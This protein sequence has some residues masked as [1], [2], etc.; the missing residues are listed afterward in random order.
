VS[1]S[2]G[3]IPRRG[4]S[5]AYGRS[6]FRFLRSCQIFFQTGCTSLHSHQ[7]C[8]MVPFSPHPHQ[9]LLLVVFLM[10][11]ILTGWDEILA[12]I[13]LAFPLWLEMVSIVC[14]FSLAIWISS[15]EKVLF[16]SATHFFIDSLIWGEF[17][18]LPA[19]SGY[20]SFIWCIAGK[21]FLP[22]CRWFLWL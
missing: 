12:W 21:N 2:F 20:Q 14:V 4:V 17:F 5:G 1:H 18:E 10:M 11:A 8:T 16:S 13:L 9:H 22:L 15:F 7:Q 19:Y 6:K 3:Y